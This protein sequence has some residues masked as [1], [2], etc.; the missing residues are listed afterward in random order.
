MLKGTEVWQV[1]EFVEPVGLLCHSCFCVI[2]SN[3]H[4]KGRAAIR[5]QQPFENFVTFVRNK[6]AG[7]IYLLADLA[8]W[9]RAVG[10][11]FAPA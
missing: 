4:A 5:R 3:L 7:K 11:S 1:D 2:S 9:K 8:C 10:M 6:P